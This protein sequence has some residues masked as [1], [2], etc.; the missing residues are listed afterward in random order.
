MRVLVADCATE[1]EQLMR[2][3][4][5]SFFVF[6]LTRRISSC[7][8]GRSVSL[9]EDHEAGQVYVRGGRKSGS[10]PKS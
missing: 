10:N 8:V 3:W 9:F 2:L 6:G 4:R 5:R 1:P 7:A